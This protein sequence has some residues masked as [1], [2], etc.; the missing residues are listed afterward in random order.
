[1]LSQRN[2]LYHQILFQICPTTSRRDV[3][4]SIVIRYR[5]VVEP[6]T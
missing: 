1:M 4:T 2:R 3:S 6:Y 5:V